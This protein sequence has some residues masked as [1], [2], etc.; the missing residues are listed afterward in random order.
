MSKIFQCLSMMA[1]VGLALVGSPQSSE[2][3]TFP[4]R[5]GSSSWHSDAGCWSPYGPTMTNTCNSEKFWYIPLLV[6]GSNGGWVNVTATGYSN[7]SN[8]RCNAQGYYKEGTYFFSS[9]WYNLP[10]YGVATDI[11]LPVYLP[12]GGGAMI[13][14]GVGLGGK[15][16]MVNW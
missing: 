10:T 8:V 6:D 15:V 4:A 5:G 13:D 7:E 14:C 12:S 16:H 11:R 2:A 9:G 3:R 1:A